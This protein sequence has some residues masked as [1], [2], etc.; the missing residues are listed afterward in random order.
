MEMER[1]ARPVP[2]NVVPHLLQSLGALSQYNKK[3]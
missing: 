2:S 1:D 3:W